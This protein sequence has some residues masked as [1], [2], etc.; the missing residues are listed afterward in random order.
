MRLKLRILSRYRPRLLTIMLLVVIAAILVL[1]NLSDE[2]CTRRPKPPQSLVDLRFDVSDHKEGP[3]GVLYGPWI[4]VS[5][6]WPL[7]WRQYVLES[8][9]ARMK[10][11]GECHSASRLLT[12][13]ILW[14]AM[15]VIP[16][17]ACEWMLRRY[18][19]GLRWSLRSL[20]AAVALAAATCGWFVA[21]QK[22]A[23]SQDALIAALKPNYGQAWVEYRGPKWLEIIGAERYRRRIVAVS[24]GYDAHQLEADG[25]FDWLGKLPDL[26]YL[27]AKCLTSGMVKAMRGGRCMRTLEIETLNLGREGVDDVVLH[28]CFAAIGQMGQLEHLHLNAGDITVASESLAYW[29]GLTKLKSLRFNDVAANGPSLF[30]HLPPLPRLATVDASYSEIGDRDLPY[31]AALPQLKSL[32]LTHTDATGA[33][34]AALASSDS[35]EELTIGDDA[36]SPAGLKSL[37]AVKHLKSLHIDSNR[38][39]DGDSE[40]WAELAIDRG[41][42]VL[43]AAAELDDCERALSELWRSKPGIV[44][45]DACNELE[46]P[47]EWIESQRYEPAG[48]SPGPALR[49]LLREWREQNAAN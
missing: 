31:L 36:L 42:F 37:L 35:L 9:W 4:N 32:V 41:S 6:G 2:I 14:L 18:P 23:D 40:E 49:Q 38:G 3:G 12:N 11:L 7:L 34:L 21:L 24:F 48:M 22:R 1:A 45:D 46:R 19:P 27:E 28:D 17:A 16:A 8:N 5:Y 30:E 33:G 44:I 47:R 15:L 29:S 10:V 13:L 20:M 43:V 25:V 26:Q 39:G